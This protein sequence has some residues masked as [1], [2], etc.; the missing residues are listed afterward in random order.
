MD[1]VTALS[2][3][4]SAMTGAKIYLVY[5]RCSLHQVSR[6]TTKVLDRVQLNAPLYA[7]SR[8]I[9]QKRH[10]GQV[11]RGLNVHIN[12]TF[13]YDEVVDPPGGYTRSE[14]FLSMLKA[15]L[16]P[17][18][19]TSY[20][21]EDEE[22]MET[23]YLNEKKHLD[24]YFE[25]HNLCPVQGPIGHIHGPSCRWHCKGKK[26]ALAT[27]RKLAQNITFPHTVEYEPARWLKVLPGLSAFAKFIVPFDTA[28]G[29][30]KA[31]RFREEDC[32]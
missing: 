19:T 8:L 5:E 25:F 4:V 23:H 21:D 13:H 22:E 20:A 30:Y 6:I 16:H 12:N 26:S 28:K 11:R 18:R 32:I 17:R 10:R 24:A 29:V 9:R 1:M 7:C 31:T 3:N 27:S 15:L 2:K 14:N